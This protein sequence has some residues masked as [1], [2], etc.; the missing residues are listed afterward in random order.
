MAVPSYTTL[1]KHVANTIV[2]VDGSVK[3]K[4]RAPQRSDM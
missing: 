4:H 2:T 1:K 3:R